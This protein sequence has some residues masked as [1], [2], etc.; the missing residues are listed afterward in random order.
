[1]AQAVRIVRDKGARR[2]FVGATHGVFAGS[3][4]EKLDQ[5]G[6]D[7]IV[8]TDTVPLP[9]NLPARF[10]CRSVAPLLARAIDAIHYSKSVS[11]LF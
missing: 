2:V 1:M 7:G 8:L 11:A 6:A 10:H 3:A 5:S 9:E 4:V